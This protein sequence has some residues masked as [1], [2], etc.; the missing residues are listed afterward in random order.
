MKVFNLSSGLLH[1]YQS[2]TQCISVFS[3][4]MKVMVINQHT[5][6]PTNS[7]L[8]S[9]WMSSQLSF[10]Y[11]TQNSRIP[12]DFIYFIKSES[13]IKFQ[14]CKLLTKET[15]AKC[16][17]GLITMNYKQSNNILN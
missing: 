6:R 5:Q 3:G 2:T 12:L 9:E 15:E 8:M 11:H 7:F 13:K 4:Q 14:G 10:S 16:E 17:P 1:W